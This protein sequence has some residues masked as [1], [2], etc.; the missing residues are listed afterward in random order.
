MYDLDLLSPF[1]GKL[2]LITASLS[3]SI[4]LCCSISIYLFIL[5]PGCLSIYTQSIQLEPNYFCALGRRLA[6]F[7]MISLDFN[8]LTIRTLSLLRWALSLDWPVGIWAAEQANT[9]S[10]NRMEG[11]LPP[12]RT[13]MGGTPHSSSKQVLSVWYAKL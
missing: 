8:K 5:P 6:A 13:N 10:K 9:F 12:S 1:A 7:L 11:I 4:N 3:S 2:S